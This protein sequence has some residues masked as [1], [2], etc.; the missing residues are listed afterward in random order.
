M[1]TADDALRMIAFSS[2]FKDVSPALSRLV[3]ALLL[4]VVA[5]S[6]ASHF[7]D[8]P[9]PPVRFQTTDADLYRGIIS[10]IAKG[11]DY[12]TVA[13]RA[14]RIG[15][16]PL[17][18]FVTVRSPVLAVVSATLGPILTK[19]LLAAL[20]V[21]VSLAWWRKLAASAVPEPIATVAGVSILA[22]SLLLT[23][24]FMS[25]FHESWAA[26]LIA[27]SLAIRTPNRLIP[28]VAVGV[29]A[30]L[31]REIAAVYL[32]VML[33]SAAFERNRREFLAV[34]AGMAV[35]VAFY[36]GHAWLLERHLTANEVTSPG[37][38]GL[39]GWSFYL[40][41]VKETSWLNL[42]PPMLAHGLVPVALFGW[43]SLNLDVARRVTALVLAY[44]LLIACFARSVNFYWSLFNTPFLL[45]GLVFAG[46]ALAVLVQ[47]GWQ[48]RDQGRDTKKAA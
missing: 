36:A 20:V 41:A 5:L 7:D 6:A 4:V 45:A 46:G 26:L 25:V 39:G 10:D 22:S 37:W 33:A 47:T 40:F 1:K 29:L 13:V 34:A 35:V 2:R 21:L 18:P 11:E 42:L 27:L 9:P 17:R 32:I 44:A 19:L 30:A 12:Y 8:G 16:Y 24:P 3:L 38:T 14:H 48:R 15:N 23:M 43:A 31:V 28:A